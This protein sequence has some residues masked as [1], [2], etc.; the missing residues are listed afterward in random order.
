M[1]A[2]DGR[3]VNAVYGFAAFLTDL[4]A[5]AGPTHVAACFDESL[6]SSF[7]NAK[8]PDER[9]QPDALEPEELNQSLNHNLDYYTWR[10]S[11]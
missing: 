5:K 4:L 7:R 3:P 1:R 11:L 10:T 9:E 6:S 2:P 8:Y